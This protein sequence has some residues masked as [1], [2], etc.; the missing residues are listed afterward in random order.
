MCTCRFTQWPHPSPFFAAQLLDMFKGRPA[1]QTGGTRRGHAW[2]DPD[3]LPSRISVPS[4]LGLGKSPRHRKRPRRS[5]DLSP[6]GG[7]QERGHGRS[8]EFEP[9]PAAPPSRPHSR[10]SPELGVAERLVA[11]VYSSSARKQNS[12]RQSVSRMSLCRSAPASVRMRIQS[13]GRVP[14]VQFMGHAHRADESAGTRTPFSR[15]GLSLTS[16]MGPRKGGSSPP[17]LFGFVVVTLF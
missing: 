10:P 14:R 2:A 6:D 16:G 5:R 15:L 17:L 1:L 9:G 4:S 8:H 11:S 13:E 3:A 12:H 7:V